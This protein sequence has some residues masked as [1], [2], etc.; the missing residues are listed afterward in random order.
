MKV[1]IWLKC[2]QIVKFC[3]DY[4]FNPTIIF[5]AV[6]FVSSYHLQRNAYA[7]WVGPFSLQVDLKVNS[8]ELW[9]ELQ[10]A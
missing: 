6:L 3:L 2:L 5:S 8:N 4:H 10:R 9:N 7:D 1:S